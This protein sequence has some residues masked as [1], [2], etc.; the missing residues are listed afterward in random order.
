MK[1]FKIATCCECRGA[2]L[3]LR[4]DFLATFPSKVLFLSGALLLGSTLSDTLA[5]LGVSE[6]GV[7]RP[8]IDLAIGAGYY[9]TCHLIFSCFIVRRR[10]R[11][12]AKGIKNQTDRVAVRRCASCKSSRVK[13]L[14]S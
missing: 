4:R 10:F 7:S 3:E 14:V 2:R 1:P 5:S 8:L 6:H 13:H 11:G 9:F 12:D